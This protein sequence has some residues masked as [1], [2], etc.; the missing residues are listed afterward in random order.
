MTYK[1]PCYV[2]D[3]L[4]FVVVCFTL[5]KKPFISLSFLVPICTMCTY[6]TRLFFLIKY[7]ARNGSDVHILLLLV[8]RQTAIRA[9]SDLGDYDVLGICA[10]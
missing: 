1:L 10:S 3:L 9:Y 8:L 6:L 2:L 5:L 4:I 7:N